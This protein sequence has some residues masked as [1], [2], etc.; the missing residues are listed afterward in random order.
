MTSYPSCSANPSQGGRKTW[1]HGIGRRS[2]I[3]S[4][5]IELVAKCILKNSNPDVVPKHEMKMFVHYPQNTS[6]PMDS[7]RMNYADD[8]YLAVN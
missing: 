1:C 5:I 2:R 3:G 7:L 4:F 6:K 8:M